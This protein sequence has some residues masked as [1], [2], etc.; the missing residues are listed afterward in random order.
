[1]RF[2]KEIIKKFH[3]ICLG[4]AEIIDL[5][6]QS[7]LAHRDVKTDNFVFTE[8]PYGSYL[9]LIDLGTAIDPNTSESNEIPLLKEFMGT[10]GY[11]SPE[12]HHRA[13]YSY[14]SDIWALGIV[15]AEILT[16]ENYQAKLKQMNLANALRGELTHPT[17][18][19]IM[20]MMSDVFHPIDLAGKTYQQWFEENVK[21]IEK[22]E[23]ANDIE[24]NLTTYS[25]ML[26]NWMSKENSEQRPTTDQ[27]E[28]V[29]KILNRYFIDALFSLSL[30]QQHPTTHKIG[31][32]NSVYPAKAQISVMPTISQLSS[33]EVEPESVIKNTTE[34]KLDVVEVTPK[35]SSEE[36]TIKT[37]LCTLLEML[38]ISESSVERTVLPSANDRIMLSL[39]ALQVGKVSEAIHT[40]EFDKRM[41]SLNKIVQRH[42]V[43]EKS[44]IAPQVQALRETCSK[45]TPK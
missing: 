4:L 42:I 16:H 36:E 5:H 6:K 9:K 35:L 19:Q 17:S 39:F 20:E 22:T 41:K 44:T 32:R 27:L 45:L 13:P 33:V 21:M 30:K 14:A 12:V 18:Q 38:S 11:I 15:F 23:S 7:N 25:L 34:N 2:S 10:F 29:Y 37:E 3:L 28:N 43:S 1:M 26:I 31:R 40:S 24:R 8:R